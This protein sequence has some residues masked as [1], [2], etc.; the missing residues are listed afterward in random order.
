MSNE[1]QTEDLDETPVNVSKAPTKELHQMPINDK[2]NI[3]MTKEMLRRQKKVRIKISS[4]ERDKHAVKVGLNGHVYQIPRD[5][6]WD[7]PGAVLAALDEAMITDYSV[8]LEGPNRGQV[9]ISEVSRFAVQSKP[10]EAPESPKAS[11]A[12]SP[13]P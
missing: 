10:V 12:G 9:T 13:K 7:V 5:K 3:T 8:E 11:A 4:T 2:N 1:P 6:W